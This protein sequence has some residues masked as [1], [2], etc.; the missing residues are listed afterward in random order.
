[1]SLSVDWTE[2]Q[3]APEEFVLK[4][5]TS[6]S[7]L[8]AVDLTGLTVDLV[9]KDRTGTTVTTTGDAIVVTAASGLV[10]YTPDNTDLVASATP[11]TARFKVTYGDGSI[12]YFPQGPAMRWRVHAL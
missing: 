6:E 11:H 10:K 12:R 8:A 4:A 9:L 7:D 3:T 2:G 5:G 1:M